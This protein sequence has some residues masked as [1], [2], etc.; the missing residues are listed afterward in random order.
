LDSIASA[1]LV[2]GK[3]GLR[4]RCSVRIPRKF[5][6]NSQYP[7]EVAM[8]ML[9]F[10]LGLSVLLVACGAESDA[11]SGAETG[12]ETGAASGAAG[13]AVVSLSP[14]AA[15]AGRSVQFNGHVLDADGL[16]T[17]TKLEA[18]YGTRLPDGAYW[19]DPVCGAFGAWGGPVVVILPAGLSLGGPVPANASGGGTGVFTN[20]RELHAFD[21][22]YLQHLLG[23]IQPGRYFTDALGN[24]GLEGGPVLVNLV[25]A[26]Q[27]RGGF[28]SYSSNP[29]TGTRS[30]IS[31]EGVSFTNSTGKTISWYPGLGSS[32][33]Q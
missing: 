25:A 16:A 17:L 5:Q 30:S 32:V 12:A 31:S 33:S 23:P 29:N 6:V 14:A 18:A 24:A 28:S 26:A 10:L 9:L 19:Y 1:H 3:R 21:V 15:P 8:P 13:V 7:S 27:Q 20:G 22:L 2:F 4:S 11:K